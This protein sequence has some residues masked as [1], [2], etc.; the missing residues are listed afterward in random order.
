MNNPDE[1]VAAV[2]AIAIMGKRGGTPNPE[3]AVEIWREVLDA[4]REPPKKKTARR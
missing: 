3:T 1:L 2:L 4:M